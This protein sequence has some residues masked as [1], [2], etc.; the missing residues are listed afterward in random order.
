MEQLDSLDKLL[1]KFSNENGFIYQP[2]YDENDFSSMCAYTRSIS[3]PDNKIYFP[4][5]YYREDNIVAY[6]TYEEEFK[7]VDDVYKA[8]IDETLEYFKD[9]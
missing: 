9:I 7:G 8:V 6:Q 3:T 1:T 4:F 2:D 5:L